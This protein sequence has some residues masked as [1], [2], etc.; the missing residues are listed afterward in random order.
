M[1]NERRWLITFG[2]GLVILS[3]ALYGLHYL[4]F[5]DIHHIGI[6]TLADIAFLPLE[7]LLVTL[8]FHQVLESRDRKQRM[9]KLNMVI[10]TFFSAIGT[11]LLT[12]ISNNDP[13][14]DEIRPQLLVNDTWT[15][16]T[17][18]RVEGRLKR[19]P[20][21]IRIEDVDLEAV[22]RFLGSREEFLLRLLE[23]PVLLEHEAFTE[24]LRAVFHFNEELQRR[25]GFSG[26][27]GTDTAH[28][29]HDL[30]RI[31][32][33]LIW[34]WLDYMHYLQENYPY[35]FSFAMR[36]NPFDETATAIVG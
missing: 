15:D 4:I 35:L 33:L 36:T 22:K 17:F 34:E 29:A 31:Y 14:L 10:G 11:Q 5:H 12:Y 27:P 25:P 21:R 26:L 18:Q 8:V 6:Y 3:I 13:N 30:E 23:N 7:V 28:L 16:E 32:G 1:T 19:H 9:D 2:A 20:C 24:L